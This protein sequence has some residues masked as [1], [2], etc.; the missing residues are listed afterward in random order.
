MS[1]VI[2]FGTGDMGKMV[3]YYLSFG[4]NFQVSA[5][6]IDGTY[7]ND[8][9]YEGLPIVPFETIEE[10]FSPDKYLMIIALGYL[11]N[12]PNQLR[13]QRF[14]EAKKKGYS[15]ITYVDKTAFVAQNSKIGE[16]CIISP[17]LTIEPSVKIGDDVIARSGCYIGHD[18]TIG[19]HCFIGPQA[20]IGGGT[21]IDSH[22]F[23]GAN[24]TIRNGIKIGK[25]CI[26]GAG[27]IILKD[28]MDNEV[29][30]GLGGEPLPKK[31]YQIRI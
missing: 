9:E 29:Y 14:A 1:E 3:R 7:I 28:T 20:V 13:A 4:S 11:G 30:R 21:I 19:D 10:A 22:T 16:N 18:V 6:T 26:V 27:A 15:L 2:V 17:N 31:S 12:G 23:I 25:S 24:S 5:H 8:K